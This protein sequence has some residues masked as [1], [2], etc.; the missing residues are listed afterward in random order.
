MAEWT[1]LFEIIA[2]NFKKG[3]N[4]RLEFDEGLMH[5]HQKPG[6]K[7]CIVSTGGRFRCSKCGR[8]WSSN[9]VRVVCHMRLAYG[10]GVVK[11]RPTRQKCKM[12][13]DAPMEEPS[14]AS[15]NIRTLMKNVLEKIRIKC[16][17]E[18]LGRKNRPFRSFD[19]TSPH[20]P[21]HC[22]ACMQGICPKR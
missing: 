4:W 22:E 2:D 21:S 19:T 17:N 5:N 12:C 18:N 1:R 10:Q 16:Y 3:D 9:M 7:K 6:W 13:T 8:G 14:I 11:V 15:D 20:E